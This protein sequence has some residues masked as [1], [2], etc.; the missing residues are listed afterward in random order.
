MS[1][2]RSK[3]SDL[4]TEVREDIFLYL[5]RRDL[6]RVIYVCRLF[7]TTANPL[8][9]QHVELRRDDRHIQDTLA[10]L[11]KFRQKIGVKVLSASI[12]SLGRPGHSLWPFPVI[13]TVLASWTRLRSIELIGMPFFYEEPSHEL[14]NC[15]R[16]NC[17]YLEELVYRPGRDDDA[18]PAI[19]LPGL[20][21]VTWQTNLTTKDVPII[22]LMEAS[23]NTLTHISFAGTVVY[24]LEGAYEKFLHLH[25]PNLV[26][27][28]LGSL[29]HTNSVIRTKQAVTK[30]I[31]N[32][33]RIEHLSLGRKQHLGFIFQFDLGQLKP[34]SL[35]AL[36]S[37]VGFPE[38]II[39]LVHLPVE[40]FFTISKLSVSCAD[41]EE[42]LFAQKFDRML[43]E[44][45]R[46][47]RLGR[48]FTAVQYLRCEFRVVL[49]HRMHT[50]VTKLNP[51]RRMDELSHWFPD[52]VYW[53]TNMLP[54][55]NEHLGVLFRLYERVEVIALPRLSLFIYMPSSPDGE[56]TFFRPI[57]RKCP[58]LKTVIALKPEYSE[59]ED[60]IYT[61]HRGADG[62]LQ[63][64]TSEMTRDQQA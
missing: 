12:R 11:Q 27:L 54:L 15:L 20:K 51:M 5:S 58:R 31:L 56:L 52:V 14:F 39:D 46:A 9:Y 29:E 45:G 62:K 64:V 36:K 37:F 63:S 43:D 6:A 26:S 33:P 38:N 10:F 41:E 44:F 40:S 24:R 4:P 7:F 3:F 30:F 34:Y 49:D 59:L 57:A 55:S 35:P 48:K 21:K 23:I 42:S 19:S 28:E 47:E 25:F 2:S 1:T 13:A 16:T 61:L 17:R 50:H 32:H 53:R 22:S 18:M 60:I 8:L